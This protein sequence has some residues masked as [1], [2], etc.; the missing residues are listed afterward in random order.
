[1]RVDSNTAGEIELD[2]RAVP[3]EEALNAIASKTGFEVVIDP[4]ITRPPVNIAVSMSPVE[5]VLRQILRGRNY[6]LV[7]DADDGF[8]YQV[9]VLPP[10]APPRP[11]PFRRPSRL[12]RR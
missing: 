2:A 8:L 11:V 5:D 1:L 10:P 6:A 9:I 7:R 4:G 12:R 3:L